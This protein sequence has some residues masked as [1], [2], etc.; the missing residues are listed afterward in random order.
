MFQKDHLRKKKRIAIEWNG[1]GEMPVELKIFNEKYGLDLSEYLSEDQMVGKKK[2]VT[3]E[4]HMIESDGGPTIRKKTKKGKR[5]R[6]ITIKAD[7]NQNVMEWVKDR[8]SKGKA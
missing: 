1:D 6:T 2:V 8:E 5:Y 4:K 7:G 3:L